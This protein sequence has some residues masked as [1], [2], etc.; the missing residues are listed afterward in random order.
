MMEK[1]EPKT[2]DEYIALFP[3]KTQEMLQQIRKSIQNAA[4][5]AVEVISYKMPA[6]KQNKVLVYFAAYEKHI[7]FYPTGDGIEAFKAE[8]SDFK[9]SKGAVQ[10]PLNEP[11]PLDLI[12]RITKFKAEKD[13]EKVKK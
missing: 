12:T 6:F 7:G 5:D 8:F 10:F 4:P 9:W 1:T 13:L 2:I 11:L 3:I